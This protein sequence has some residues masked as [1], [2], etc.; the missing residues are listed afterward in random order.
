MLHSTTIL[1][2]FPSLHRKLFCDQI[3][4]LH[5]QIL[6]CQPH[7]FPYLTALEGRLVAINCW[8]LCGECGEAEQPSPAQFT[9]IN[10]V[11]IGSRN[12]YKPLTVAGNGSAEISSSGYKKLSTKWLYHNCFNLRFY[13]YLNLELCGGKSLAN[14][15]IQQFAVFCKILVEIKFIFMLLPFCLK[16]YILLV[17]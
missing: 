8:L 17:L 13:P 10:V 9:I 11:S 1:K 7:D 4:C 2:K 14:V 15:F 3:L 16:V 5:R 12:L 6:F